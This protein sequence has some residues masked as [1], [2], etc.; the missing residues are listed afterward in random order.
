M[1]GTAAGAGAGTLEDVD[2]RGMG[3]ATG[4]VGTGVGVGGD[5]DCALT[6][7]ETRSNAPNRIS[8]FMAPN[9]I[10]RDRADHPHSGVS[11]PSQPAQAD[12]MTTRNLRL[13][14]LVLVAWIWGAAIAAAKA[15][16]Q[17]TVTGDDDPNALPGASVTMKWQFMRLN[18]ARGN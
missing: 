10:D 4:V 2:E 7:A 16:W 11:P 17:V 18:E 12:R 6:T 8:V 15:P 9:V 1:D 13:F 14:S 5:G 3:C